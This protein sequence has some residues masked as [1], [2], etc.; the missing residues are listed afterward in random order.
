VDIRGEGLL[1]KQSFRGGAGIGSKQKCKLTAD[2][3]G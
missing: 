2:R 1:G 3:I